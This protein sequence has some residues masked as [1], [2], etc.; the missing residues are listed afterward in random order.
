MPFFSFSLLSEFSCSFLFG[1]FS[2]SHFFRLDLFYVH[3][4]FDS[5]FLRLMFYVKFFFSSL[6]RK[7]WLCVVQF[8]LSNIIFCFIFFSFKFYLFYWGITFLISFGFISF[9]Y[10][11]RLLFNEIDLFKSHFSNHGHHCEIYMRA[12]FSVIVRHQNSCRLL[13][14]LFDSKFDTIKIKTGWPQNPKPQ[15]YS[16]RCMW[17]DAS[18]VFNII[19]MQKKYIANWFNLYHFLNKYQFNLCC[20]SNCILIK[21]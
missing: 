15:H 13:L 6:F 17:A 12:P 3:W 19:I 10:C 11:V 8:F 14:V 2:L 20:Q 4:T 18:I 9:A 1:F 16:L 5:F 21:L 7:V